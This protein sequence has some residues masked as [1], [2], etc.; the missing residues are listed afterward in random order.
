[1][2]AGCGVN[3]AYVAEQIAD[4][5]GCTTAKLATVSNKTG[6]NARVRCDGCSNNRSFCNGRW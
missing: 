5:E 4:S 2:V 1:M 6:A 3:K